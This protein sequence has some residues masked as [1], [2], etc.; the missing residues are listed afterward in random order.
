MKQ[1]LNLASIFARLRDIHGQPVI[2][3]TDGSRVRLLIHESHDAHS[4]WHYTD[5]AP[6]AA[7]ELAVALIARSGP[8]S[9]R[10]LPRWFTRFGVRR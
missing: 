8:Q 10:G 7:D 3:S 9:D 2:A 4:G 5:L 6:A 1:N